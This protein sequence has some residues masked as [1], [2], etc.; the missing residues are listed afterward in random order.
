MRGEVCLRAFQPAAVP[1]DRSGLSEFGMGMKSAACWFAQNW[2]VRTKALGETVE[3]LISF[4]IEAI[5]RG[6]VEEL[7]VKS[8]PAHAN[9]HFTEIVLFNLHKSSQGR[10]IGKIKEHLASIYREFI[11]KGIL[12][13]YFDGELLSYQE[14][15]VLYAPFYKMP[16]AEPILWRKEINFDFGLGLSVQ[17][18]AAIRETASTSNAGFALFRRDRLIQ[19]SADESYR[20]DSIFGQ[21]NSFIYQRVFGELHLTGFEVSHTKDGFKWDEQEETFLELLKDELN[22]FLLPYLLRL[23]NIV[24]VLSQG[25]SNQVQKRQLSE[26]QKLLSMRFPKS[27]RINLIRNLEVPSPHR[28]FLSQLCYRDE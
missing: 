19:G 10:T 1:L 8:T 16:S 3:R 21:P 17:G 28:G 4:N 15:K 20:P 25:N 14:A 26:P 6:E 12:E 5:I 24:S 18:F 2:K 27:C 11:R 22:D 7:S 9:T 23:R 13:L